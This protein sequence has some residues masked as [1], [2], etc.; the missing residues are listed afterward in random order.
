MDRVDLIIVG[1]G[2]SGLAAAFEARRAGMSAVV[3]EAAD[4]PAGSWPRYYDSL[5]LFSPARYSSLPGTPFPGDDPDRYPTRDEVVAY[6]A[7]YAAQFG[8]TVRLG[9]RVE[10]VSRTPGLGFTVTTATGDELRAAAVIAASGHFG[11]PHRPPLPGLESFTGTVLH[12]AEY[13][14]PGRFAGQRV[15]VVG[16]GNSAIQIAV[17]LAGT[18]RTTLTTRA[19]ITW[20]AQRPLGRDAHWWLRTTGFDT[21]PL[22]RWL[23]RL[24]VSVIDDG[25]YRAAVDAQRPDRRPIFDRLDGG[26]VVW[27]DGSREPLDAVILATGYRPDLPY[28]E[29]TGALAADGSPLHRRGLSTT[30]PGLGYVGL[31]FQRS[32]SSN[33]L[34]G[35]GRDAR[36]VVA[37]LRSATRNQA[38]V[39]A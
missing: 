33:T 19:P 21:A 3:L 10:S 30:V 13:Q 20:A 1:A 9:T 39:A 17:E 32:F 2:Q 12:A 23:D 6:L 31:E 25:P 5:R 7:D 36:H 8:D 38:T 34:R 14:A 29:G 26:D 27:A 28:L 4:T 37:A 15:A 35:C 11:A 24:P 16:A 22:G 18:A